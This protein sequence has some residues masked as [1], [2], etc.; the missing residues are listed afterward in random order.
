[1]RLGTEKILTRRRTELS[2]SMKRV[3]Q[4]LSGRRDTQRNCDDRRHNER[5]F[6]PNRERALS[7]K[8]NE[9]RANSR[10]QSNRW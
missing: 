9:T 3:E 1:M 7:D 5:N 4:S 2:K 10:C 8:T 6:I